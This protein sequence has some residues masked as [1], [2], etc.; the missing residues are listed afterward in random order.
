MPPTEA[1]N[2][3][4]TETLSIQMPATLAAKIR[5]RVLTGEFASE[6]EAVVHD[7]L[8]VDEWSW[9]PDEGFGPSLEE[10]L[11]EVPAQLERIAGGEEKT[12]SMEEVRQYLAAHREERLKG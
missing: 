8:E 7:L 2:D 6:S 11:E 3:I 4:Q 9:L 5:A 10:M 1:A 12:Y